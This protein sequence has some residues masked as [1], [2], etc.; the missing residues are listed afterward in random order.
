MW[1]ALICGRL[2]CVASFSPWKMTGTIFALSILLF[3]GCEILSMMRYAIFQYG[4]INWI[5][6]KTLDAV[7][8]Y[9]GA[10]SQKPSEKPVLPENG[11]ER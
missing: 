8:S 6:G 1:N 4:G 9:W 2:S 7:G 3:F 5:L 11:G 10:G